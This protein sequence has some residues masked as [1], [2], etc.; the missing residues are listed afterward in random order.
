MRILFSVACGS[1]PAFDI[2]EYFLNY[3]IHNNKVNGFVEINDNPE[4]TLF[5]VSEIYICTPGRLDGR[6]ADLQPNNKYWI[7]RDNIMFGT[8]VVKGTFIPKIDLEEKRF[9]N[10]SWMIFHTG[11]IKFTT[12]FP[13]YGNLTNEYIETYIK[14]TFDIIN[15]II[16]YLN[17]KPKL[18]IANMV[19]QKE[20]LPSNQ[21]AIFQYII[22]H[23]NIIGC[24]FHTYWYNDVEL[25]RY[26]SLRLYPIKGRKLNITIDCKGA[27]QL[28]GAKSSED[29]EYTMKCWDK[30]V[31][32]VQKNMNNFFK[33]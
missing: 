14:N 8:I 15:T 20:D 6:V 32:F 12:G 29:I 31:I 18:E 16:P 19:I 22:H 13:K 30:L 23:L 10:C 11:N 2:N 17:I 7:K 28:W 27:Y 24:F 33:N 4:T 5:A 1:I 3:M 9:V 26:G 21:Y 25:G